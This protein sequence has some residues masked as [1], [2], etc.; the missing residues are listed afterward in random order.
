MPIHIR[1]CLSAADK[2][3][4]MNVN[5]IN[6]SGKITKSFSKKKT[7]FSFTNSFLCEISHKR[8]NRVNAL[9]TF[10]EYFF[11]LDL[12]SRIPRNRLIF[13][14]CFYDAYTGTIDSFLRRFIKY[15]HYGQPRSSFHLHFFCLRTNNGISELNH[16]I[17]NNER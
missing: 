13:R 17:L 11:S 8:L 5:R 1:F 16:A 3:K 12:S 6:A 7:V 15:V 9:Q 2:M 10:V 14:S 4:R